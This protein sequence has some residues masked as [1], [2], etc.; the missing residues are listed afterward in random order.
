MDIIWI[1]SGLTVLLMI[2]FVGIMIWAYSSARKKAFH[3]ASLIPLKEDEDL[4]EGKEASSRAI[5]EG[6]D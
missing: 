4:L 2:C 5:V 1:R 3:E 6:K